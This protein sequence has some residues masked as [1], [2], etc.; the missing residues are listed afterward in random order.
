M[1]KEVTSTADITVL[2]GK[3]VRKDWIISRKLL[4]FFIYEG[5]GFNYGLDMNIDVY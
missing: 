5:V 3:G 1:Y 4:A 2:G